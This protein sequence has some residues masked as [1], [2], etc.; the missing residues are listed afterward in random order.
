MDADFKVNCFLS[1]AMKWKSV[2]NLG[3]QSDD[4][5]IVH[6]FSSVFIFIAA[7]LL[8]E[9]V[10]RRLSFVISCLTH[11]PISSQS[12]SFFVYYSL[13]FQLTISFIK[14]SYFFCLFPN[15]LRCSLVFFDWTTGVQVDSSV[16][17]NCLYL[18]GFPISLKIYSYH[19]V[20]VWVCLAR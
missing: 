17:R 14:I 4:V 10:S 20:C 18:I 13:L 19:R 3:F 16:L 11:C 2:I 7:T 8:R 12:S 1:L 5:F 15:V 9:S 6:I